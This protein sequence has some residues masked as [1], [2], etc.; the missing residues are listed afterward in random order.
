MYAYSPFSFMPP[1]PFFFSEEKV[2]PIGHKLRTPLKTFVGVVKVEWTPLCYRRLKLFDPIQKV[3]MKGKAFFFLFKETF[4]LKL[5]N[6]QDLRK[7]R[8]NKRQN[9]STT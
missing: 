5:L 3:N 9:V 7:M 6:Y 4:Y 1:S 2:T 8:Q